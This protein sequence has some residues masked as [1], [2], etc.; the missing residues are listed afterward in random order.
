MDQRPLPGIPDAISK[1]ADQMMAR[2]HRSVFLRCTEAAKAI[3]DW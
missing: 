1:S 3:F 2:I